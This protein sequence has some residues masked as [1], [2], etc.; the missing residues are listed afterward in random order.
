MVGSTDGAVFA[1]ESQAGGAPVCSLC[2]VPPAD[3]SDGAPVA[4]R[5]S[6]TF[7]VNRNSLTVAAVIIGGWFEQDG[8][9][10]GRLYAINNDATIRWTFPR[11]DQAPIGAIRSA[12]AI[13][14]AGTFYVTTGDDFLYAIGSDGTLQW[15]FGLPPDSLATTSAQ[16]FASPVTSTFVYVGTRHGEVY[17]VNPDGALRWRS[18]PSDGEPFGESPVLGNQLPITPTPTP[19]IETTPVPTA[20]VPPEATLTP[21]PTPI[22][23]GSSLFTISESGTLAVID[24]HQGDVIEPSRQL[25]GLSG[26]ITSPILLSTDGFLVFVTSTATLHAF[27]ATIGTVPE[28][29]EDGIQLGDG[30][31]R[32]APSLATDGT[33]VVGS[34]DGLLYILRPEAP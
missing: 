18:V 30:P 31:I 27:N 29:W 28:G 2:F 34:D 21:S 17:A 33:L 19:T 26:S 23:A 16:P 15:R 22:R 20:T 9:E 11:L 5:G 14:L 8:S 7:T 24:T 6:P 4:F 10:R 1:F 3:S 25:T 12:P 13:G 32:S